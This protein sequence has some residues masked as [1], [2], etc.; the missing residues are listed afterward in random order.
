[1]SEAVG[2]L[3]IVDDEAAVLEVLSDYFTEQGYTVH[4]AS[5]GSEALDAIGRVEPDLILLD[6][7]MP[8]MDG[9]EVLKRVR[10]TDPAP[11]VIMVTANEDVDLARQ[12]LK[13]GALEYVSK[14]FDFRHL[15]RVVAAG[16]VQAAPVR[17][18]VETPRSGAADDPARRLVFA[19]FRAVRAMPAPARG[20]TGVRLEAAAM[21]AWRTLQGV[22]GVAARRHLA[23]IEL[24]VTIA[25][26]L[27]DLPLAARSEVEPA[28]TAARAALP[29]S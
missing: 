2:R 5:S 9:V 13:L 12:M 19:V 8:G 7:R 21:E 26:D 3:L 15:D 28:L 27:G 10:E 11:P 6:V 18:G 24:L 23:E 25:S 29:R 17:L 4:T 22:D 14:P 16:L 20:S 1:V